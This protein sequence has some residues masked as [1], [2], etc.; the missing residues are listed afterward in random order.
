MFFCVP[1]IDSESD[2]LL[3]V[4]EEFTTNTTGNAQGKKTKQC[5]F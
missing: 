2:Q 4:D 5:L 3:E 1:P